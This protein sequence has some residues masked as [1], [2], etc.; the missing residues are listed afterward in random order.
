MDITT[1]TIRIYPATDIEDIPMILLL[2][3][4]SDLTTSTHGWDFT[5]YP[6]V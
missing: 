2:M 4:I 1:A 6:G 5:E 3:P